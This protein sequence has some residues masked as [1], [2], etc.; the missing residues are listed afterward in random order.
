MSLAEAST[1][2]LVVLEIA[3]L[4]LIVK[5]VLLA[6]NAKDSM[7]SQVAQ[8]R[9]RKTSITVFRFIQYSI[10]SSVVYVEK[11]IAVEFFWK[12]LI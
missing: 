10:K 5:A 8:E 11:P 2:F 6:S 7:V 12:K 1:P 9:E 3:I 4:M